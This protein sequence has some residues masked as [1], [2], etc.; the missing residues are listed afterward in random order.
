MKMLKEL[1]DKIGPPGTPPSEQSVGELFIEFA[2]FFRFYKIY[3]KNH[4]EASQVNS[5]E[6]APN[7]L[8]VPSFS[9]CRHSTPVLLI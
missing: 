9:V 3:V 7:L 6:L 5:A 1:G 8:S 2:P 4:D